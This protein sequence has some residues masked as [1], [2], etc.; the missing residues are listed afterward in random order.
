[1]N[2]DRNALLSNMVLFVFCY[3]IPYVIC[4]CGSMI[5]MEVRLVHILIEFTPNSL[6]LNVT[7]KLSNISRGAT[8]H[9]E[10][11]Y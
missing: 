11:V 10:K 6:V 3:L 1:M 7:L 4:Y 8:P 9:Q 5:K 2:G